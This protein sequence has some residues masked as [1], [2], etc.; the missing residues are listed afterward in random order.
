MRYKLA[1]RR[2]RS[3]DSMFG[4]VSDKDHGCFQEIADVQQ[5]LK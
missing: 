1:F 2:I 3:A 5:V 4:A